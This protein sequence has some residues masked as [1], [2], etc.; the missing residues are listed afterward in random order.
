M[1]KVRRQNSNW[2]PVKQRAKK[3]HLRAFVLIVA[4]VVRPRNHARSRERFEMFKISRNYFVRDLPQKTYYTRSNSRPFRSLE[5]L[6]PGTMTQYRPRRRHPRFFCHF[7]P[8]VWPCSCSTFDLGPSPSN[9]TNKSLQ[10]PRL[11]FWSAVFLLKKKVEKQAKP[12]P[13]FPKE[14]KAIS[15]MINNCSFYWQC[16]SFSFFSFIQRSRRTSCLAII[17]FS[18]FS[19]QRQYKENNER[20]K[21]EIFTRTWV[22][23]LVLRVCVRSVRVWTVRVTSSACIYQLLFLSFF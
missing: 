23:G 5:F 2:K 13:E 14:K 22:W 1:V 18:P 21:K 19:C 4:P 10:D 15:I 8:S 6:T 9:S 3:R 16:F 17:R 20:T 11:L 7:R 12:F